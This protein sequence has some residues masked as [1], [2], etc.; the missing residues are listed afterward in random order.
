MAALWQ[1]L[2][3][4]AR[5][6]GNASWRWLDI[7]AAFPLVTLATKEEFVPQM[8]DFEKIGGVSFHKGCYPGQE[9]VA[10]TQYLGKVKRHLVPPEQRTSTQG[11]R[12]PALAGQ[13]RSVLRHGHDRA[14]SPAGGL[15]GTGGRPVQLCRPMSALAQARRSESGC[16]RSTRKTAK[17]CLIVVGWRVHPDY[18]LVVAANRD[19]FYA[20]P[21]ARW[22]DFW[23]DAPQV[24]GGRDL[25]AGGTWL[26]ITE[27]GRFAAVTNVREPGMAKGALARFADPQFPD[28]RQVPALTTPR[29]RPGVLR[30]QPAAGDGDRW[31]TAPIAT[32]PRSWRPAFTAFPTICSTAPGP[33][34]WRRASVSPRPARPARRNRTF[35]MLADQESLPT[36]EPARDR[37]SAR[38]GTA[39]VGD[40]RANRKTTARGPRRLLATA[41]EHLSSTNA[42][43]A[44]TAS[45]F[46]PR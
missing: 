41:M 24:I 18:P 4:K 46:S 7:Q 17:M 13:P 22:P 44:R 27:S 23:P 11:G 19:E 3:V 43:S 29:H 36:T 37:R 9:V 10:R 2:T 20:R 35:R 1:K 8:A 6:A 30:L 39:A 42:A 5:P 12:R 28:R 16:L 38:V 26:G 25:E 31:S 45:R 34:C 40:L 14:P 15:R 32:A 21:S 33:S